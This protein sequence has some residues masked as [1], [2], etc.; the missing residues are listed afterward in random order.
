MGL[1]TTAQHAPLVWKAPRNHRTR[2]RHPWITGPGRGAGFG[3]LVGPA[4]VGG[5]TA[6]TNFAHNFP[7]SLFET[8]RKRCN[9]NDANSIFEQAAGELRAKLLWRG[10]LHPLRGATPV[11]GRDTRYGPLHPITRGALPTDRVQ[12]PQSQEQTRKLRDAG[13][14][15]A[16]AGDGKTTARQISHAIPPRHKSMH[17]QKPQNINDQISTLEIHSGE[18]HAKL[19]CGRGLA[20]V[21]VGGGRAWPGFETRHRSATRPHWCGGRR[22]DRRAR[23]GFEARRRTK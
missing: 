9:S 12:H 14:A 22:R 4:R 8:A 23:A 10:S 18:L 13:L 2:P 20:A 16:P 6:Q 7:R 21:P 17:V 1:A 19:L 15:A 11:M 3:R 5:A